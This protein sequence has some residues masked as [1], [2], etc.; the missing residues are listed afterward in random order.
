MDHIVY[1]WLPEP[2]QFEKDLEL[3]Q[4]RLVTFELE[5]CSQNYTTGKNYTA[6]VR[7]TQHQKYTADMNREYTTWWFCL[8]IFRIS[9]CLLGLEGTRVGHHCVN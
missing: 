7:T 2:V 1:K 6:Q 5:D 9:N 3:P 8:C 4:F